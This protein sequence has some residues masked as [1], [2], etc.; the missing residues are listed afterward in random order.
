M[1]LPGPVEVRAIVDQLVASGELR[2]FA[3]DWTV[4]RADAGDAAP[5]VRERIGDTPEEIEEANRIAGYIVSPSRSGESCDPEFWATLMI[6]SA[7]A[8]ADGAHGE[9]LRGSH[10]RGFIRY[11]DRARARFIA[12]AAKL[13]AAQARGSWA[14]PAVSLSSADARAVI[15]VLAWFL[16]LC[17]PQEQPVNPYC[18]EHGIPCPESAGGSDYYP[19]P[20][21]MCTC[22]PPRVPE[23][24]QPIADA[25]GTI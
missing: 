14:Q 24:I 9:D 16:Y 10:V 12:E 21:P 23:P 5:T 20:P 3:V 22:A 4:Q 6:S 17:T 19:C 13:D 1:P 18:R 15:R 7:K 11:L 8:L 2:L 25:K